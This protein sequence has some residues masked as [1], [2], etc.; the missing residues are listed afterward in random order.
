MSTATTTTTEKV[1]Y[2]AEHVL[3]VNYGH[4]VWALW[5]PDPDQAKN[6]RAIADNITGRAYADVEVIAE[7]SRLYKSEGALVS[8]WQICAD[9]NAFMASTRKTDAMKQLR[10]TV[11]DYFN[12]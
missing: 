8:G 1:P 9:G 12:R 7:M 2:D 6:P 3:Y 10:E 4:T 11:A 5:T